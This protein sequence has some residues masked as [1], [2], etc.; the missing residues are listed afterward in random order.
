[1][2]GKCL[3]VFAAVVVDR[4]ILFVLAAVV[5]GLL[6]AYHHI[7][8]VHILLHIAELIV[9]VSIAVATV[10]GREFEDDNFRKTPY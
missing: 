4:H 3:L 9:A 2:S 5:V 1:M 7:V 10:A 6:V 8:A